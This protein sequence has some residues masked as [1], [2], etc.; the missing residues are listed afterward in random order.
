MTV[1]TLEPK[2]LGLFKKN[3]VLVHGNAGATGISEHVSTLFGRGGGAE[4]EFPCNYK[5][6]VDSCIL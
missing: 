6:V 5:T 4:G 2:Y 1:H 3:T